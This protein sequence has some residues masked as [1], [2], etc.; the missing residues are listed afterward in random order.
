MSSSSLGITSFGRG[1][2]S[3][4]LQQSVEFT[5]PVAAPVVVDDV[6]AAQEVVQDR[7]G[8]DL[9]VRADLGPVPDMLVRGQSNAASAL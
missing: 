9:A 6:D 5:K 2:G 4:Q 3:G 7:G 1:V 8:Q